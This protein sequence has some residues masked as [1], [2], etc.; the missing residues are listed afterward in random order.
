[1]APCGRKGTHNYVIV[2]RSLR[3]TM[4]FPTAKQMKALQL[5]HLNAVWPQRCCIQQHGAGN[6]SKSISHEI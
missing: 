5:V 1:M 6:T 3:T 2:Q 4:Y